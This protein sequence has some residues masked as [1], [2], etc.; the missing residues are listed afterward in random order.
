M[1][2]YVWSYRPK[3]DNWKWFFSSTLLHL[4]WFLWIV[5]A[6]KKN[7]KTVHTNEQRNVSDEEFF[8]QSLGAIRNLF[9]IQTFCKSNND[10]DD[11]KIK[12]QNRSNE[13]RT[14]DRDSTTK[15]ISPS[16]TNYLHLDLEQTAKPHFF[17]SFSVLICVTYKRIDR[18]NK[19]TAQSGQIESSKCCSLSLTFSISFFFAQFYWR[20]ENQARNENYFTT[21]PQ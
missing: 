14:H 5:N 13:F 10:D 15:T 11:A 18:R 17:H 7:K 2:V 20:E 8:T 16:N 1:C 3:Q 9:S 19:Y 4:K 12:S 6:K 21:N